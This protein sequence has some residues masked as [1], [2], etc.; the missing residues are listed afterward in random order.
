MT[1]RQKGKERKGK[2]EKGKGVGQSIAIFLLEAED[3]GPEE[4]AEI[5]SKCNICQNL[6]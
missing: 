4:A 5:V 2:E 3:A 1:E 6:D